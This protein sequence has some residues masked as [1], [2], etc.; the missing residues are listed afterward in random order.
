M[1]PCFETQHPTACITVIFD[2]DKDFMKVSVAKQACSV[3]GAGLISSA[4]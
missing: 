2:L 4:A 1:L 3:Q